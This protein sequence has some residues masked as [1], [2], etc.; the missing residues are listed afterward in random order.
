[1]A[2]WKLISICTL[3]GVTVLFTVQNY[4][5]VEL[6]FLFWTLAMSR[7]LMLFLILAVGITIGWLLRGHK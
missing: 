3:T 1:M 7:A 6:K 5:V 4:E 2:Q